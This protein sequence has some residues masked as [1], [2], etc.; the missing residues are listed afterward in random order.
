MKLSEPRVRQG[1][2]RERDALLAARALHRELRQ[3]NIALA[4]F[5][6]SPDY[7]LPVLGAE[8]ARLFAGVNL[9][10][11]TTAGEISE[12]GYTTGTLTGVSFSSEEFA[13]ASARIDTLSRFEFAS[14]E[15]TARS[16]L[17]QLEQREARPDYHN[18]FAFLLVDGLSQQEEGLVG[19]LSRGLREI[20]LCGGSAADG[21]R[22]GKTL[23]FHQGAFHED[24]AVC[25]LVCSQRP[26]VVFKSQHFECSEQKMVVTEALPE[27][28]IVS[29]INGE[30]AALE[31]A[32]MVGLTLE[33][34]TP[35]V[36][37]ANPV[38]V[39]V[40]GNYYVRSI[41][42][43]NSDGSLTFFCAIAEG[44]VL[45]VARGIDLVDNLKQA[46]AEV[47]GTLGIPEVV[48][49]CDC[50]LR[51]IEIEQRG[52]AGQIGQIFARNHTVGFATYGEQ[53]NTL[54]VNQTFTGVAIGVR[55]AP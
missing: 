22:F 2:T 6:C 8:L 35:L 16:L 26:F 9:I 54:H 1:A 5:Y 27:R 19:S 10:G 52:L 31:Y 45:T 50:V 39:K 30:P 12:L 34:L 14:G 37:A 4:I 40:G 3:P 15:A 23:V 46:F 33:K 21:V 20:K 55:A 28:R 17:E 48:L 29:E 41:Q 11:C 7:D 25:S 32:R 38:M 53:F 24:I 36:F 44:I 18:T 47:E 43:V 49:G 42:K 51:H 13:V